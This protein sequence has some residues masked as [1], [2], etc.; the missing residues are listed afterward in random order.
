MI[1]S[2]DFEVQISPD[3]KPV[4]TDFGKVKSFSDLAEAVFSQ[5][6]E[7]INTGWH[8]GSPGEPKHGRYDSKLEWLMGINRYHMDEWWLY[9]TQGNAH[10]LGNLA[11]QINPAWVEGADWTGEMSDDEKMATLRQSWEAAQDQ[12]SA[13]LAS[14][15]GGKV[16]KFSTPLM[17]GGISSAVILPCSPSPETVVVFRGIRH[18][19]LDEIKEQVSGMLRTGED[20]SG[21][22]ANGPFNIHRW[23]QIVD[24]PDIRTAVLN[25]ANNPSEDNFLVLIDLYKVHALPVLIRESQT[26]L[27]SVHTLMEERHETFA[28]ALADLHNDLMN[29]NVGFSPFVATAADMEM[30]AD[31]TGDTGL[32]LASRL[33]PDSIS[34]IHLGGTE[35]LVKGWIDPWQVF[36]VVPVNRSDPQKNLSQ[37]DKSAIEASYARAGRELEAL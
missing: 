35:K 25:L 26:A 33:K 6:S 28:Q 31:F 37:R 24:D 18:Q 27:N 15:V 7:L 17:E 9:D 21:R 22:E 12:R 30:T 36:A 19:H 5:D 2:L 3:I 34:P 1:N 4:C 20:P 8:P 16:Y 32:V 13:R 29:G 14:R 11:R 10:N 23:S